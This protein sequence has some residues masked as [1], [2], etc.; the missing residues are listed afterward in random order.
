MAFASCYCSVVIFSGMLA[1]KSFADLAIC[2][3]LIMLF[4][5]FLVDRAV[6]RRFVIHSLELP[7]K[8]V[9][10]EEVALVPGANPPTQDEEARHMYRD[11]IINQKTW[12]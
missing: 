12:Q 4:I 1:F 8:V 2:F 6:T 5:V 11:P 9:A 7:L 10:E 3:L